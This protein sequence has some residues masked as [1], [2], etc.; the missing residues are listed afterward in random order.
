VVQGKGRLAV[1]AGADSPNYEL[2]V[3]NT[4]SPSA[5]QTFGAES[6]TYTYG[7]T[8]GVFG[9][10][11][12][13]Q[14]V[15]AYVQSN[16]GGTL[17]M[18]VGMNTTITAGYAVNLIF[19][20]SYEFRRGEQLSSVSTLD[21][22]AS[23]KIQF[24]VH[25][26][27]G[28]F[29]KEMG[30]AVAVSA[31]GAA[32]MAGSTATGDYLN[33]EGNSLGEKFH[34]NANLAT[35]VVTAGVGLAELIIFLVMRA[36]SKERDLEDGDPIMSLDKDKGH[37]VLRSD[38]WLLMLSPD[39]AVLG[40]NKKYGPPDNAVEVSSL[41][42]ADAGTSIVLTE[43]PTSSIT[44]QVKKDPTAADADAKIVIDDQGAIT[45]EAKKID[46]SAASGAATKVT[47]T[48]DLTVTGGVT[49]TKDLKADTGTFDTKLTKPGGIEVT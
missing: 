10:I 49:V 23:T 48:G 2:L 38:D 8:L 36:R 14:Y 13:Q 5:H 21:Q 28:G 4:D 15:G 37:A 6:F 40:K 20:D 41:D 34:A 17:N 29:S 16:L 24:S 11:F 35:G 18:S 43:K 39:W 26:G 7:T 27:A 12:A 42:I 31:I 9:G 46:I 3:T 30:A 33:N 44:I 32:L 1:Y 22:R 45:I 19:A 25:Q 47:I